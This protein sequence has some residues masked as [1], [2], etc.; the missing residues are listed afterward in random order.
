MPVRCRS[1]WILV[2]CR[3]RSCR[4]SR[5]RSALQRGRRPGRSGDLLLSRRTPLAQLL[6]IDPGPQHRGGGWHT[7]SRA[8]GGPFL[9]TRQA[10]SH[11]DGVGERARDG[12]VVAWSAAHDGY[13]SLNPPCV[14]ADRCV[15]RAD[16]G[17]SRS[18]TVSR[19]RE[20]MT[21]DWRSTSAPTSTSGWS[22]KNAELTWSDGL[23]HAM[24]HAH[25]CRIGLSW[26]LHRGET[27]PVLGWYSPSFGVKQPAWALIGQRNMQWYRLGHPH[28]RA[29]VPYVS[30]RTSS[31]WREAPFSSTSSKYLYHPGLL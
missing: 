9:W 19:R 29:P 2:D 8:S 26:S 18:S 21:S 16:C 10:R 20:S 15:S 12:E 27:D 25:S 22:D 4:C 24:R 1:T 6:P 30:S 28:D 11:V 5:G 17:N 13:Q 3:P 14:T 31:R 23:V 7:T